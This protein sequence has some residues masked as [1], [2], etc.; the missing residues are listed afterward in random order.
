M[1]RHFFQAHFLG[2][3]PQFQGNINCPDL[4]VLALLLNLGKLNPV[5]LMDLFNDLSGLLEG[6][7]ALPTS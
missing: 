7:E 2:I 3:E 1:S 5:A 4:A 6:H